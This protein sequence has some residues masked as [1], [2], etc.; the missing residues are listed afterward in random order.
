MTPNDELSIDRQIEAAT[1]RLHILEPILQALDQPHRVLDVLL[2]AKDAEA[3]RSAL[4]T[5]FGWDTIQATAVMDAQF[6]RV[7]HFDRDKIR[8]DMAE[9]RA[10]LARL[11]K[12]P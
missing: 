12:S 11:R 7:T 2:E 3:G 6:R 8:K 5:E 1:Q 4:T 10:L 9:M